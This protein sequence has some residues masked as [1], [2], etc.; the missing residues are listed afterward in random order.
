MFKP[1]SPPRCGF[2]N[3]SYIPIVALL[4]NLIGF[5]GVAA[6]LS[7]MFSV[8]ILLSSIFTRSK[9]GFVCIMPYKTHLVIDFLVGVV[10]L[11]SHWLV[12]FADNALVRNVFLIFGTFDVLAGLL[13]QPEEMPGRDGVKQAIPVQE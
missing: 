3:Y 8:A 2:I 6:L 10:A 7:R 4:P 11:S 13:S 5:R 1:T 9:W 12:G